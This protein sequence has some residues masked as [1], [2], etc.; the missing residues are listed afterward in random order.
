MEQLYAFSQTL[1]LNDVSPLRKQVEKAIIEFGG[2]PDAVAEMILALN[3]AVVNSLRHGYRGPGLVELG[4]W[5]TGRSL[6]V[7]QI[8]AAPAFDP[9]RSPIPDTEKPLASRPFGGMGIHMIRNFTDELHYE[10]T[11]DGR[12]QLTLVK[13]NTFQSLPI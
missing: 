3:E 8:D 6:V 7:I 1:T 12:N 13:Y 11:S 10:R 5:R 9:T 2:E 4:I